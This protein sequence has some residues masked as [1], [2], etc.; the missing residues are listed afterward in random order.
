MRDGEE[1]KIKKHLQHTKYHQHT[2]IFPFETSHP[3]RLELKDVAL[4]NIPLY[5]G[6]DLNVDQ[7]MNITKI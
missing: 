3:L 6:I 2:K 7:T 4:L 1:R 5:K